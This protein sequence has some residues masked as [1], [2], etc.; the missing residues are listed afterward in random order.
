MDPTAERHAHLDDAVRALR[1]PASWPREREQVVHWARRLRA[2]PNLI[3]VDVETT[4]LKNAYAVQI[5]AIARDGT[6][7][8]NELANPQ[9]VSTEPDAIALH[10]ITAERAGMA[11]TFGVLLPKLTKVLHGQ[12][13][14]G[15]SSSAWSGSRPPSPRRARG[16]RAA[17]PTLSI[18]FIYRP[19]DEQ[20]RQGRDFGRI[21]AGSRP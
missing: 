9:G 1:R 17:A 6:V 21:G 16:D 7:L 15:S 20:D 12:T 4:G 3:A 14:L 2:E 19:I 8:L 11:D 18:L 13:V 10:G 5:A